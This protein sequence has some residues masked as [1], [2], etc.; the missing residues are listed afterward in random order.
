VGLALI[1]TLASVLRLATISSQPFDGDEAVHLHPFSFQEAVEIDLHINPPL[2]RLLAWAAAGIDRS[3]AAVRL[4]SAVAGALTVA[5]IFL[6]AR[7]PLGRG[8]ALLSAFLLAVN[9]WHIHYCQTARS[10]ALLTLLVLASYLLL[11]RSFERSG[12]LGR[13]ALAATQVVCIATNYIALLLVPLDVGSACRRLG[14]RKA[15]GLAA[16]PALAASLAAPFV[17]QG[18]VLKSAAAQAAPY[19]AGFEY[20]WRVLR[21]AFAGGGLSLVAWLVVAGAA[22][23]HEQGRPLLLRGAGIIA[24]VAILGLFVPIELRYCLPALP[25]LLAGAA[26]GMLALLGTRCAEAPPLSGDPLRTALQTQGSTR[27]T[28]G[29]ARSSLQAGA[30]TTPH[31]LRRLAALAVVAAAIAGSAFPL[32]LYFSGH[33]QDL[34]EEL[35]PDL[36]CAKPPPLADAYGTPSSDRT[37]RADANGT[38]SSDR[39]GQADANGTPSSD[40]TGRVSVEVIGGGT[41]YFRVVAEIFGGRYPEDAIL[42]DFSGGSKITWPGGSVTRLDFPLGAAP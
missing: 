14:W 30:R 7:G 9:P 34:S 24:A 6:A 20:V 2:F 11:R 26:S 12:L 23:L 21:S 4:I 27:H 22:M 38:P 40:R 31:P 28:P 1:L 13:I 42:E 33:A 32:G 41:E 10:F 29:P 39:T 15:L 16:I 8:A 37:G 19:T 18:I 3:I 17:V 36:A 5:L 35:H 25:F